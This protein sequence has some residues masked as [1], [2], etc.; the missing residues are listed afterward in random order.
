MSTLGSCACHLLPGVLDLFS[1]L[2]C[3]AACRQF[4]RF[5]APAACRSPPPSW[6]GNLAD[7][8]ASIPIGWL[9]ARSSSPSHL[10]QLSLFLYGVLCPVSCTWSAWTFFYCTHSPSRSILPEVTSTSDKLD[11]CELPLHR[12][13]PRVHGPGTLPAW[14]A[15]QTTCSA[16]DQHRA[17]AT[18]KQ[19][20][21]DG[22][23]GGAG[24]TAIPV[25]PADP[26]PPPSRAG[27][28]DLRPA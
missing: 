26:H 8:L 12:I 14:A 7:C 15:K 6:V 2:H 22:L 4:C 25:C 24:L 9:S 10:G 13:H 28:C 18:V 11:V 16:R 1:L 3:A 23:A 21:E 17:A 27:Q 5:Q 19:Q 20:E